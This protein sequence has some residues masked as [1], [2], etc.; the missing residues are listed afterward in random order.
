MMETKMLIPLKVD[1]IE[2]DDNG[3]NQFKVTCPFV[4][5]VYAIIATDKT[6]ET[7]TDDT[8]MD[9]Y[10]YYSED[11]DHIGSDYNAVREYLFIRFTKLL[12]EEQNQLQ[13]SMSVTSIN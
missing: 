7:I 9:I 10:W 6:F 3:R 12:E 13:S 1:K 8:I 4:N 2:L 11:D 5:S